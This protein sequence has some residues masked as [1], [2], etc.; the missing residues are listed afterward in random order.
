MSDDEP[1][2]RVIVTKRRIY[3]LAPDQQGQPV[4]KALNLSGLCSRGLGISKRPSQDGARS[5]EREHCEC[6]G[7][8]TTSPPATGN[9]LRIWICGGQSALRKCKVSP[10]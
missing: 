5:Y 4:E 6:K 3:R 10:A 2:E 7:K 1:A 9:F 8:M